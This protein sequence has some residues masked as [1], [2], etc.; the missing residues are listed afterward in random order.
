GVAMVPVHGAY[1][2]AAAALRERLGVFGTLAA[3][4]AAN[5]VGWH[6]LFWSHARFERNRPTITNNFVL[7]C[8]SEPITIFLDVMFAVGAFPA[9]RARLADACVHYNAR[10]KTINAYT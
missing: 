8:L 1:V 5:V 4:V 3:A 2:L 9:L 6:M 7:A 10:L